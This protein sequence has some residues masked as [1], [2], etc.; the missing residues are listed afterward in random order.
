MVSQTD[1]IVIGAGINGMV[2]AAELAKA[3]WS[4]A[5]VDRN[6]RIGGFIASGEL[7]VPGYVHD[8]YSSWHPLFLTGEGYA[9]L[10][11]D[12]HR[13][14]LEY[15]NTDGAV[16][17]SVADDGRISIAYRDASRTA[18]NL[19]AEADR[20]EYLAMLQEMQKQLPIVGGF[21]A[22]EPI[23]PGSLKNFGGL[24]RKSDREGLESALRT[25]MS[26][27]R[28]WARRRFVGP[29]VDHLFAPWLLHAG[30]SPDHAMG[31]L[32]E[33]LMA[34]SLHA[35]GMAVP[36][37]GAGN[38]LAAFEKLFD[39]LGVKLHLGKA[40]DEIVV[41]AGKAIGVRLGED[42]LSANKAVLASVTPDALY[43]ELMPA[44]KVKI[45]E[46]EPLRKEA[47][48]FRYGRGAM[49]I[50]VALSAPPAWRDERLAKV[51]M[52]HFTDGSASTAIACAQAEAG[53]LPVAPT[54]VLGRQ[55][56]LDP[57]RV[58]KGGA[59]LWIQLQEV[60][61]APVGDAAG[62]LDTSAGWTTELAEAYAQRVLDRIGKHA[63]GLADLVLGMKIITPVD[64]AA[65]N[66]NARFGDPYGGSCELDQMLFWRP[67]PS[68][69]AHRT[70]V[71]NLWHIGASTHP[72]PGLG[73]GSG[74][75]VATQL[76]TPPALKQI[77]DRIDNFRIAR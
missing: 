24:W 14:G 22:S 66:P 52:V 38:F 16:T 51:P 36:V 12:L 63:P 33:P 41:A 56:V 31:G 3:G 53:L 34:A 57:S 74:H 35:A 10:G 46:L 65:A 43:A 8:T 1:A 19:A 64:L 20:T 5:L 17:A 73:G 61:Y 7:T 21:L 32:M 58:P 68:A 50:H 75:L 42:R 70:P 49:Q 13:H 37:G 4:V 69:R 77:R 29:E 55:D 27:G 45:A 18:E 28:A 25:T 71:E 48:Q 60:P 9:A 44:D 6:E 30:L 23:S 62:E 59:A 47:A 54:V 67:L 26:S 76:T 39:E 40:V 11:E 15:R 2:A 72:G